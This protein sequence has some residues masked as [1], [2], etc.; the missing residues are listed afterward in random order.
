MT[1]ENLARN[2]QPDAVD[3]LGRASPGSV[4]S[5]FLPAS[6]Y[7]AGM[8]RTSDARQRLMDAAHELI[9]EFSYGSVTIE[10]ICDRAGVKKGSFYYF[11][12][13]KSELAVA[14]L[15]A[16]RADRVVKVMSFFGPSSSALEPVWKYLDLVVHEQFAAYEQNGQVLGCPLF[17]L[18]SEIC[19]QDEKLR[20]VIAELLT[21][22]LKFFHDCLRDAVARGEIEDKN[23][24]LKA[25]LLWAFY[26]G[27]LTRARIENNP[28]LVR[29]LTSEAI[30]LV[31]ARPRAQV[32]DTAVA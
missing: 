23:I 25:R 14:A 6:N 17:T 7:H 28:E 21:S 24:D 10:A 2:A 29:H 5:C 30:E 22:G 1:G 18:G 12:N 27:T 26:E 31:G 8:G 20:T 3:L 11:F 13:S 4:L 16:Y 9:W 32:L 15:A 19:T